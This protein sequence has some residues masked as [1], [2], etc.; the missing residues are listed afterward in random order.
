MGFWVSVGQPKVYPGQISHRA[1]CHDGHRY[2]SWP[3]EYKGTLLQSKVHLSSFWC[4]CFKPPLTTPSQYGSDSFFTQALVKHSPDK[5][6]FL[7]VVVKRMMETQILEDELKE[8]REL[9]SALLAQEQELEAKLAEESQ[10]KDANHFT[11][12]LFS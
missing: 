9:N 6:L 4:K 12:S 5:D 3:G 11:N 2:Q 8:V 10:A 1:V 7:K